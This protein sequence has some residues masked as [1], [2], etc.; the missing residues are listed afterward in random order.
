MQYLLL[1]CGKNVFAND[2]QNYVYTCI[3]CLF[4]TMII[5]VFLCVVIKT[6]VL[7][8][9]VEYVNPPDVRPWIF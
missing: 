8:K 2:A 1:V 9:E 6:D 5:K 4:E 3:A 7:I